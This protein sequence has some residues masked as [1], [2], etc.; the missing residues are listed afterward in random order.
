MVRPKG[1]GARG[2]GL[3]VWRLRRWC[4]ALVAGLWLAFAGASGASAAGFVVP[5]ATQ[6]HV[7]GPVVV[8][9]E[10]GMEQEARAWALEIPSI[11]SELE[12][13]L[14]EDVDDHLT[15][16]LTSHAG[17]LAEASGIGDWASGVARPAAGEMIVAAYGP[18]GAPVQ[19]A[20]VLRHEL[21]HVALHRAVGGVALPAWFHEGV[22]DNFGQS[23]SPGRREALARGYASG[24]PTIEA[25]AR[26]FSGTDAEIATAYA[27]SRDFV[28]HLWARDPG[29]ARFHALIDTLRQGRGFDRAVVD[30]YGET[31]ESLGARWHEGL[32]GRLSWTPLATSPDAFLILVSPMFALAWWRRRRRDAEG[33]ARLL[34]EDRLAQAHRERVLAS[35]GTLRRDAVPVR[36]AGW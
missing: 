18:D 34:E 9:Y 13:L 1:T 5:D 30:V 10:P 32:W 14:G 3:A 12:T 29:K 24:V 11:W 35:L 2:R 33:F 16:F 27:A 25:L 15:L 4:L 23:V 20:A 21:A 19:R 31:I 22:A 36:G 26:P 28:E 17:E 8:H 6:T 7:R